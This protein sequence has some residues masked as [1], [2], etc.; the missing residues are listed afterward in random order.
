M[1][2]KALAVELKSTPKKRA[3][4]ADGEFRHL[5]RQRRVRVDRVDSPLIAKTIKLAVLG[6]EID[7]YERRVVL[8]AGHGPDLS[9]PSASAPSEFHLIDVF[10]VP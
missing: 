5:E 4:E 6:L 1:T 8:Q 10:A 2:R 9:Q 3:L 7:A